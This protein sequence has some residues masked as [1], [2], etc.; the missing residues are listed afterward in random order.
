ML[1][2]KPVEVNLSDAT[3]YAYEQ[4]WNNGYARRGG[5][6][7]LWAQFCCVAVTAEELSAVESAYECGYNDGIMLSPQRQRELNG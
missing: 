3:A 4:G 7:S 1:I 2:F 6:A 5:S